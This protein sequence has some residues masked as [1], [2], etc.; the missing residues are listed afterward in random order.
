[1]EDLIEMSFYTICLLTGLAGVVLLFVMICA[2]KTPRKYYLNPGA[3]NMI[4]VTSD[5]PWDADQAVWCTNDPQAAL[6]FM[7]TA[8]EQLVAARGGGGKQAEK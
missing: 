3:S 2:D 4:C 1:M 8:N 5:N 7:K 6:A